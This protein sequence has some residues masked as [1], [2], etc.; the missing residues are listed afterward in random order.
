MV[1]HLKGFEAYPPG[2]FECYHIKKTTSNYQKKTLT[3]NVL[4][5]GCTLNS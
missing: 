5:Q 2:A 3:Y 4:T 1:L